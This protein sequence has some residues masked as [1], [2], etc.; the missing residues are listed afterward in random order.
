[1]RQGVLW[2]GVIRARLQ[3]TV[4]ISH[5]GRHIQAT[6]EFYVWESGRDITLSKKFLEEHKLAD[7]RGLLADDQAV[8]ARATVIPSWSQSSIVLPT[9]KCVK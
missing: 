4:F 3:A 6:T 5:E 2:T 8:E 1:M 7:L 9:T